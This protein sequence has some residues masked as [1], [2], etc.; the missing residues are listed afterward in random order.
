[1]LAL[2]SALASEP[3]DARTR[4][5]PS[6]G[7]ANPA[8]SAQALDNAPPQLGSITRAPQTQTD[9]AIERTIERDINQLLERAN[10]NRASTPPVSRRGGGGATR[11]DTNPIASAGDAAWLLGLIYAHGA[12][13]VQDWPQAQLWFERALAKG[14]S[15]GAAGLAWCAIEGCK[16]PP[17]PAQA[18]AY[19]AS[20]RAQL[21]ARALYLEWWVQSKGTPLVTS[22]PKAMGDPAI[23]N[24]ASYRLPSRPL[25]VQAARLGDVHALIEL[26]LE[27]VALG[28]KAQARQW[29][30]QAAAGASSGPSAAAHNLRL[31]DQQQANSDPTIN[32]HV[33]MDAATLLAMAQRNHK[34]LGQPANYAEAI[35]LYRLAQTKGSTAARDMLALIFSRPTASGQ[36]DIAW[37][38]RIAVLNLGTAA[39]GPANPSLGAPV[40]QRERSPLFDYLPTLWKA[41]MRNV[42]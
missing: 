21:P 41:R 12:G 34:G 6:A 38:Q 15:L 28:D 27:A 26:G 35:R 24:E 19:I 30:E 2:N 4:A 11:I 29:F 31:L 10:N 22:T 25:L 14:Q 1:M 8:I 3:A 20:M 23:D 5:E 13:V 36:L 39:G 18:R 40:F 16:Q 37:M 7:F 17:D 9:R 42:N 33:S 32:S